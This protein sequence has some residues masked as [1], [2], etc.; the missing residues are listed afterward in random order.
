MQVTRLMLAAVALTIAAS[1]ARSQELG[2]L[3][4]GRGVA[5]RVCAECHAVQA[6]DARSP[7]S[8]APRFA[9]IAATPGMTA[10]ALNAFLHTSHST[11]PNV[12]LGADET[13]DI[14]AYILSL[15]K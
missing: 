9:A 6:E 5:Q 14:I 1:Q 10:A 4:K 12:V 2:D 13:N 15:K 11:M 8:N 7:N 3:Q